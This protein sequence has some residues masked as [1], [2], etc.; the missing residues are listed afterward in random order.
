MFYRFLKNVLEA[1]GVR[2][3]E[4]NEKVENDEVNH[5]EDD[6]THWTRIRIIMSEARWGMLS[7][8]GERML[9]VI[10]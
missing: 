2:L 4:K 6:W 10:N 3:E 5:V 9:F 7:W 8:T 1:G